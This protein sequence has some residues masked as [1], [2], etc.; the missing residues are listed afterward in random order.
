MEYLVNFWFIP[1]VVIPILGIFYFAAET[2]KGESAIKARPQR[3]SSFA[4]AMPPQ[5]AL[6]VIIRYA[7]QRDYIIEALDE[8]QE[9]IVLGQPTT[10][11]D[12]GFFF[13]IWITNRDENRSLVDVGIQSKGGQIGPRVSRTHERF[14]NGLKGA[15]LVRL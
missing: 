11:Q 6:K 15:F 5:E 8:N 2:K 1:A 4:T 3:R 12:W 13:P 7:F 10:F 14:L 9:W